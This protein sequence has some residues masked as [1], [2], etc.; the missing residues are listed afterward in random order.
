M[1]QGEEAACLVFYA[2]RGETRRWR[3]L[4]NAL[5]TFTEAREWIISSRVVGRAIE[6]CD[7]NEAVLQIRLVNPGPGWSY[8]EQATTDREFFRTISGASIVASV[9]F[10]DCLPATLALYGYDF[11]DRQQPRGYA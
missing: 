2:R 9:T 7:T 11:Q 1:P 4:S 3:A 5:L 6:V 8:E 10:V